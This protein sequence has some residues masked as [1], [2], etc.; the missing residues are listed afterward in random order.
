MPALLVVDLAGRGDD[1]SPLR[2]IEIRPLW[3]RRKA[4][5]RVS[6]IDGVS[7]LADSDRFEESN[8]CVREEFNV[9]AVGVRDAAEAGR[10]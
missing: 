4:F 5:E 1:R 6:L 8:D 2:Q 10:P 7:G 9:L 3:Q